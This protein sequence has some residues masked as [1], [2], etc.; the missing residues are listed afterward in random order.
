MWWWYIFRYFECNVPVCLPREFGWPV[1]MALVRSKPVQYVIE[2]LRR[3]TTRRSS[4]S[5]AVTG[6]G[7][8]NLPTS[9]MQN[10]S[11]NA[12]TRTISA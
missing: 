6:N 1:P 3:C 2:K 12:G 5:E 10:D 8:S 11:A 4:T 7:D 9:S